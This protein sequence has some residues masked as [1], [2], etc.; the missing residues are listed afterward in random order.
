MK[1]LT[2]ILL[3]AFAPVVFAQNFNEADVS[4]VS[5]MK[6]DSASA[7]WNLTETSLI[8][9]LYRFEKLPLI[10]T[11]V[12]SGL[13][14]SRDRTGGNNDGFDGAYSKLRLENGNSVIAEEPYGAGCI[15]R[16]QCTH[17][18]WGE[19]G[20]LGNQGEHIKI[21]V[22][23]DFEN[24]VLDIP[25][26]DLFSGEHESFPK[27][28]VGNAH[29]GFYC[30]VPIPFR[31]GFKIVIEGDHVRFFHITYHMFPEAG[32][33]VSFTEKQTPA[34]KAAMDIA[35]EAWQNAGNLDFLVDSK[36]TDTTTFEVQLNP[37]EMRR[38]DLPKGPHIVRAVRFTGTDEQR[39]LAGQGVIQ[40][41]FDD[42]AK[43]TANL[44]LD[45]FFMN[46]S[47]AIPMK[48]LLVGT[49]DHTWYNYMPMPYYRNSSI[50]LF[51]PNI[52]EG[53]SGKL[54][55]ITEKMSEN[56]GPFGY[57]HAKYN[58][59][60]PTMPGEY[61]E[62]LKHDGRGHLFGLYLDTD[63]YSAPNMCV[64]MEGDDRWFTDGF[65]RGLGN[66]SEDFFNGGWYSTPGRLTAPG[67]SPTH[68]FPT[69]RGQD[70]KFWTAAYRWF[71]AD[72]VS[73]EQSILSEIEHGAINND[74]TNY[75]SAAFF[76]DVTP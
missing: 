1:H 36:T 37:N 7:V 32:N 75:R 8:E 14:T 17:S 27:P 62:F 20:I 23:G 11:N 16:I 43:P 53:M 12:Y 50:M 60:T 13:F 22:D 25:M 21:Y 2:P 35:V 52:K 30:Y 72:P 74:I 69:F 63:G 4:V 18:L 71:I 10:R 19:F 5:K 49:N 39:N 45:F 67:F 58:S 54:E 46:A 24:P 6:A 15:R 61:Y 57:F 73:F 64:W 3:F 48:T 70:G 33:L 38:F 59:K 31:N 55:V 66:G 56:Y 34:Q 47:E 28:I 44:P 65:C 40:F 26:I 68:G 41:Y 9:D 76:Y 42:G 51:A 29:G